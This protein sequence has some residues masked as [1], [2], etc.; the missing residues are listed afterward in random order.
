MKTCSKS[1]RHSRR[2]STFY[3]ENGINRICSLVTV[4]VEPRN[5]ADIDTRV[6]APSTPEAAL[7][8]FDAGLKILDT[9]TLT[10]SD[11]AAFQRL[12]QRLPAAISMALER[13]EALMTDAMTSPVQPGLWIS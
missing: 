4:V 8:A 12:L 9:L 5:G 10:V 3:C 6:F 1:N 11:A 2:A 13:D 7:S